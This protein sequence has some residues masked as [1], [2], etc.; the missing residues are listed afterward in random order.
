MKRA[1]SLLLAL[2]LL[3]VL[4]PAAM[5]SSAAYGSDVWLQ[6][7]MLQNGVV[8]SDNI[9]WSDSYDKPRHEYYITYSPSGS[10]VTPE[11]PDQTEPDLPDLDD[12]IPGWLLNGRD[13]LAAS[14]ISYSAGSGVRP[15]AAF[16]SSVCDRLTAAA[17]AQ[18]YENL[19]YRVVGAINGDFY[20]VST[21]FPLGILI[22]GGQLL[23]GASDYYAVGF[24]ADGSVV[25]GAPNLS[26]AAQSNTGMS[27]NV[28]SI[29]K[30]RVD[31][32]GVTLLTHYFRNDHCTGTTTAGVNVLARS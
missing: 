8:L 10:A 25:M 11:L 4:A 18:Y 30:P 19:G 22:S 32:G 15:V 13:G 7:T 31:K 9:F 1:I 17:A 27:I 28:W 2:M 26:I 3:F 23:S 5:A 29:N 14:V 12:N 16:G 24:R 6:N 20:D 21:G